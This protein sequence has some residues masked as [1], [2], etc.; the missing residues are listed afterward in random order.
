M[1]LPWSIETMRPP[2]SDRGLCSELKRLGNGNVTK[3][4]TLEPEYRTIDGFGCYWYPFSFLYKGKQF[5]GIW[6]DEFHEIFFDTKPIG[7]IV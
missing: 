6:S 7:E 5:Y 2:R 1:K 4:R 3:Y